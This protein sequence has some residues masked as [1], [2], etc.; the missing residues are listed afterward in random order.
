ML[1]KI[2]ILTT[3]TVIL[4]KQSIRDNNYT[5]VMEGEGDKAAMATEFLNQ[6]IVGV[7]SPTAEQSRVALARGKSVSTPMGADSSTGGE[8]TMS[9][10]PA[11]GHKQYY[12]QV[13]P[14]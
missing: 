3:I 4:S 2:I 5:I 9:P 7:G 8:A 11:E 14:T 13:K 10:S 6:I 12:A 1:Y